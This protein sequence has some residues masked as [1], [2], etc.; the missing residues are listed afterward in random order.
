M[1]VFSVFR[2]LEG[3]GVF[4]SF[5][6]LVTSWFSLTCSS[7]A[8]GKGGGESGVCYICFSCFGVFFLLLGVGA[9]ELNFVSSSLKEF[10]RDFVAIFYKVGF[11]LLQICGRRCLCRLEI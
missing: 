2:A 8:L 3:M 5:D 10:L 7:V 6:F 11:T 1:P 9:R 4:F